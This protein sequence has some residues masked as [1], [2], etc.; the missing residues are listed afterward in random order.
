[1]KFQD[2]YE[3]L[4]V[5]RTASDEDVKRAYRKLALKW[6]PDRAKPEGR[7]AAE[8][9]FKQV[10][11][12]YE[13]LSDPEKRKKYD[14]FGEHWKQGQ[15]FT[16]P[17][18]AGGART[19]TPEEFAR[20]F[21]G[22]AGRGGG[23]SDFFTNLFGEQFEQQVGGGGRRHARYAERGADV[24]AE[25]QLPVSDAL[26]G[27]K[28]AFSIS[29]VAPCARCGGTGT[30]GQH[31]CPTCM[32]VGSVEEPRRVDLTIPRAVRDGQTLRL[33]GLGEPGEGGGEAGD[34]LLTVRLRSDEVFRIDGANI[35]AD[36]P[37]APWEALSGAKV[38]VR[39]PDG[40]VTLNVPAGT[41]AG[42]RLRLRG[43]GLENGHGVRGDFHAV[44][45]IA[46]PDALTPEQ[47][48]LIAKAGA[49][50][51]RVHGGARE[52]S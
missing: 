38:P 46:L 15:E 45:R 7:K 44:I 37:L 34:L 12:A 41:R 21:G 2:Y 14:R 43:R 10:A 35:E 28:R 50:G 23:F 13:V 16:P 5:P 51:G 27:G 36:V 29:G 31:V 32:G 26:A 11:E 30:I 4:G 6:H 9:K 33:R 39:T 40:S 19:V 18:G 49:T 3:V 47:R 20:M 24:Q 17:P 52:D 8:E 22:A 1:M 42:T 48:E 25:L